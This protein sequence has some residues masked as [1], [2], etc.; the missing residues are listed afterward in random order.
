MQQSSPLESLKTLLSRALSLANSTSVSLIEKDMIMA[1][2]RKSYEEANNL[3]ISTISIPEEPVKP[4]E[5]A[6]IIP[7]PIPVLTQEAPIVPEIKT[8]SVPL[9]II[10]EVKVTNP[11]AEQV[12][13]VEP[14]IIPAEPVFIV[15]P[16]TVVAVSPV[17]EEK[18]TPSPNFAELMEKVKPKENVL[19]AQPIEE[20]DDEPMF[21]SDIRLEDMFDPKAA[22]ELSERLSAS[23][24]ENIVTAI[25]L[26]ERIFTVNEL[27]NGDNDAFQDVCAH[28]KQLG[29]YTQAKNYLSSSVIEKYNWMAPDKFRKAKE[30]I[31]LA[32][33]LYI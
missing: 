2:I 6:P 15:P 30:F 9:E 23:R 5:Q 7:E 26:N 14:E 18:L 29:S 33:R 21:F 27:F 31:K 12:K 24:I 20:D 3:E 16:E 13:P 19:P 4:V 32:R 8:E 10:E 22:S 1:L 28:L 11:Q 25:G 17:Q